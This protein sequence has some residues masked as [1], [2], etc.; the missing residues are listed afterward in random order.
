MSTN[1]N[2]YIGGNLCG[3]NPLNFSIYIH[4]KFVLHSRNALTLL[5]PVQIPSNS[6][7]LAEDHLY[8]ALLS[9]P[10]RD[11]DLKRQSKLL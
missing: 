5:C 6:L 7:L 8:P 3:K 9:L 2:I 11:L 4:F 10:H 1:S